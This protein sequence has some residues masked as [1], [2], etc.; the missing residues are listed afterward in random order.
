[1][2]PLAGIEPVTLRYRA[3]TNWDQLYECWIALST[4]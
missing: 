3:V 2:V 1:M 4:G